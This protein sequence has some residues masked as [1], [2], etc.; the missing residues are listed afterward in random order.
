MRDLR[1]RY[2]HPMD[3]C[4][5]TARIRFI[6]NQNHVNPDPFKRNDYPRGT[7]HGLEE[8]TKVERI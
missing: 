4:I 7:L 2:G 3:N 6:E 8:I 5:I 1:Q